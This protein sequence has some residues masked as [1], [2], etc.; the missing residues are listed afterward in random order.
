MTGE[1]IISSEMLDE[2]YV[3]KKEIIWSRFL[4]VPMNKTG[5]VEDTNEV[6]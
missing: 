4:E 6:V 2:R 5:S 1:D 3:K